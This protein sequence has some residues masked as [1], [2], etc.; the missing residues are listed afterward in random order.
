VFNTK[1]TFQEDYKNFAE[2]YLGI[3]YED[4]VDLLKDADF[5]VEKLEVE[6]SLTHNR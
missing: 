3:D 6:Y 2:R 4:Y 5:P 1:Y